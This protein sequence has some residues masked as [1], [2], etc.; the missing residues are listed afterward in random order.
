MDQGGWVATYEDTTER[1]QTE[2]RL[3]HLARHD[4]L[5]ELPNR[6]ALN[7]HLAALARLPGQPNGSVGIMTINV[8]NFR[9]IND[10]FGHE[11]GDKLLRSVAGRLRQAA[12]ADAFIA[13]VGSDEFVVV[14]AA[15][16]D[17]AD[18][19]RLA[20]RLLEE[21]AAPEN[22]DGKATAITASIGI[23]IADEGP[24]DADLLLTH[25]ENALHQAKAAGGGSFR[26]FDPDIDARMQSRRSMELDLRAA[27]ANQEFR[28]EYQPIWDVHAAR[29]TGFEALLRWQHPTRGVVAPA[30][31]IPLAEERGLIGPIGT[32]V[33]NQ[34]CQDA[35]AW[36]AHVSVSVNLSV[37]QFQD[38]GLEG[39]IL[40]A[41]A[42]SGLPP[43]RLILEITE[44]VPLRDDTRI[45]TL[46]QALRERGIRIAL[47]DFGTGYSSLSYLATFPF[48]KL[49][50][51]KSFVTELETRTDCRAIVA[52]IVSLATRLGIAATAEGVESEAS[53]ALVGTMGC[54]EAQGFHFASPQPLDA[55][56]RW[57]AHGS[58]T[59]TAPR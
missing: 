19:G 7:E 42:A 38:P 31:F 52:S 18:V 53:L 6:L 1:R 23:A 9:T 45:A 36:P 37:M 46:L 57:F 50:I 54:A 47:D 32:W 41:L 12:P 2:A 17:P 25:A 59:A 26:F 16:I 28:L 29:V 35:A 27:L 55:I 13:R 48:D 56:G 22:V 49:K 5:T 8:D 10:A 43:S 34:A 39:L 51:D 30:D 4:G 58:A 3:H 20:D 14:R 40:E 21:I 15:A 44:S 24:F 33:I 11:G